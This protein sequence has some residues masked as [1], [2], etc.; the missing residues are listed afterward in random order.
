M[1]SIL[2]IVVLV[3]IG[4]F[5]FRKPPSTPP[6]TV[7]PSP[8]SEP[9]PT[10]SSQ[11]TFPIADFFPRITKKPFGIYITPQNSPVQP[12]K[13]TGYHTGTDIEYGDVTGNVPVYAIAD[14]QV[15]YSGWVKGY[16]GFLAIQH[17][18]FIATYGHLNP[19]SLVK[20]GTKVTKGQN[21][22]ILG[23]AYSTQTDGERKHLHF[24]ILKG[25]KLDFRGYIQIQS[26]LSLWL[27]PV[28][29]F[30]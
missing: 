8:T 27:D 9:S 2:I 7:L 21:I 19:T 10:P 20:S 3:L 16:G 22:A 14:G 4:F 13:F 18:D 28:S 24:G 6:I 17:P 25:S 26:E 15:I 30:Q 5:L 29:L 11:Y 12:E 23:N 1:K